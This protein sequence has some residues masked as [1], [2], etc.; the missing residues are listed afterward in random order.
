[1]VSLAL[2]ANHIKVVVFLLPGRRSRSCR[3]FCLLQQFL[4][5]RH[6]RSMAIEASAFWRDEVCA[7]QYAIA[8]GRLKRLGGAR[9]YHIRAKRLYAIWM[10][11]ALSCGSASSPSSNP[12]FDGCLVLGID[13]RSQ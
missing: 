7:A 6:F 9:E 1:V 3:L 10:S 13:E 4:Q 2:T 12:L 8:R 11:F 5:L